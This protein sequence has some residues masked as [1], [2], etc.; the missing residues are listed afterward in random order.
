MVPNAILETLGLRPRILQPS[1]V[2]QV[3]PLIFHGILVQYSRRIVYRLSSN[4]GVSI[5]EAKYIPSH[6]TQGSDITGEAED[7]SN[8]ITLKSGNAAHA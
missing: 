2:L 4:K 8:L 6:L 3:M 7:L 1:A 5:A